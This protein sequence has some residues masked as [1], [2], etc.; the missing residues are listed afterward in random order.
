VRGGNQKGRL[1]RGVFVNA[2][3][4][5]PYRYDRQYGCA[6]ARRPT[7]SVHH[8]P[9]QAPLVND[10]FEELDTPLSDELDPDRTPI[11]RQFVFRDDFTEVVP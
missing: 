9:R 10:A 8:D 3:G 5:G 4:A 1:R 2:R 6:R 11:A 7:A